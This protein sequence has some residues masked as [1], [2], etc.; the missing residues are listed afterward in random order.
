MR[1]WTPDN[2][3]AGLMAHKRDVILKAALAGFLEDG[4]AG[5]SV[6]RIAENAGVDG[7]VVAQKVKE[8]EGN[9]VYNALTHEYGDMMKMGVIVPTKVER[10]ALQNAARPRVRK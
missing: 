8:G 10:T 3:K 9:F 2:P 1:T 4:F 5:S 7:S 6:N